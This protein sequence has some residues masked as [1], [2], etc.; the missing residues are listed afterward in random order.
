MRY[1]IA[2]LVFLL[3]ALLIYTKERRKLPSF[4]SPKPAKVLGTASSSSFVEWSGN[5]KLFALQ[6]DHL[7]IT[8][9]AVLAR[10]VTGEVYTQGKLSFTAKEAQYN[11]QEKVL[12]FTD[13]IFFR[14]SFTLQMTTG[15]LS[16]KGKKLLGQKVLLTQAKTQ[17]AAATLLTHLPLRRLIFEGNPVLQTEP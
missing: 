10:R 14:P 17:L 6:S 4:S 7:A 11:R 16:L 9:R 13:A 3:L 12:T 5:Q 15:T 1:G 2:L 8:E